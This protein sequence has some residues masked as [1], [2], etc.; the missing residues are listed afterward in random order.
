MRVMILCKHRLQRFIGRRGHLDEDRLT[1][2]AAP[3]HAVQHQAVQV[4]VQVGGRPEALDQRDGAAVG[5]VCLEASLP[6]QVARDHAVHDLQHRRHQLGLR[7]QQQAQRDRQR[8]HPLAH[9][10]MGDDVVHQVRRGLR[11]APR[12]ARR[13]KA[14]PLAAEGDQLVVAAVAAAQPQEA[15][16]QD[17]AFEEGV[18]LVLHELRQIGSGG[19]FG[20]GDE[21]RGVLLHQ[22][23]QRG[24][25]RAVTLVVDRAAFGTTM[26]IGREGELVR[27]CRRAV[28]QGHAGREAGREMSSG[29]TTAHVCLLEMSAAC[30]MPARPRR[31]SNSI[32][33]Q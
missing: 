28:P 29:R 4:D 12:A 31:P 2:G 21:G 22:A 7:G 20:L 11:H 8:Q 15:V 9:R 23:V 10:H 1:V 26:R 3:V 32:S 17:A 18:E 25:L 33:D 16:G 24:L 13:A 19:G 6:E 30:H 27:R 14:A 5:L